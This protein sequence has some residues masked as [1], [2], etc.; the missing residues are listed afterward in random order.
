MEAQ[1]TLRMMVRVGEE[2]H[3]NILGHGMQLARLRC[4]RHSE[5]LKKEVST[6][7][8]VMVREG[9][10]ED[11]MYKNTAVDFSSLSDPAKGSVRR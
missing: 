4:V 6:K 1:K 10:G 9:E 11:Q 7:K 3:V 2:T 8:L 5:M